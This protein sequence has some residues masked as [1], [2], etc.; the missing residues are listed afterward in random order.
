MFLLFRLIV[1]SSP[2][3]FLGHMKK[4]GVK[5]YDFYGKTMSSNESFV[6]L[7]IMFK[8]VEEIL[9]L[10]KL[11]YKHNQYT[12]KIWKETLKSFKVIIDIND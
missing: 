7:E 10:N 11:P 4:H 2:I 6:H 8:Y 12:N 9:Y 1:Y 3:L 5:T